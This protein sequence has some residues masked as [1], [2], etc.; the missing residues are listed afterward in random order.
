MV[1]ASTGT[2][3]TR[4]TT[5]IRV[6]MVRTLAIVRTG[7]SD[8]WRCMMRGTTT[9]ASTTCTATPSTITASTRS[10]SPVPTTNSAGSS[11]DTRV[12][13]NGT[14]ATRPVKMPKASQ[15]GTPRTHS[16]SAVRTASTIMARSWPT[17]QARS[18]APRSS[19][20]RAATGRGFGETSDRIPARYR[21]GPGGG[22]EPR[23]AREGEPPLEHVGDRRKVYGAQ[24][25]DEDEEQ[26]LDHPDDEPDGQGGNEERHER[27]ARQPRR[28]RRLR[29]QRWCS[30]GGGASSSSTSSASAAPLPSCFD[31]PADA[32]VRSPT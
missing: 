23:P 10:Q 1:T 2:A 30:G 29:V 5:P 24:H 9:L 12:P 16:P 31:S 20:I 22:R 15:Y 27:G 26:H 3:T 21:R 14:T 18:V 13:K 19:S 28:R 7:G 4:P 6:P 11:V 25:G 8:T 32:A 17:T